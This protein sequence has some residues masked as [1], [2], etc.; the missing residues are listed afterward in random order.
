MKRN[1]FTGLLLV[2]AASGAAAQRANIGLRARAADVLNHVNAPADVE[3]CAA[4]IVELGLPI[5]PE[6]FAILVDGTATMPGGQTL[7]LDDLRLVTLYAALGGLPHTELVLYLDRVARTSESDEE[8]ERGLDLLERLGTGAE[9]RLFFALANPG[10]TEPPSLVL[11]E[12]LEQA[13]MALAQRDE[14]I[15]T[16]LARLFSRTTGPDRATI[17]TMLGSIG[18]DDA[19]ELLAGLLGTAGT[20]ADTLLLLEFLRLGADSRPVTD[21]AALE[22][23]R[24]FL[25]HPDAR[26]STIACLAVEKLRDSD[27][28]PELITLL[29]TGDPDLQARARQTLR[30]LTGIDLGPNGD[31]WMEW[32]DRSLAWWDERASACE[33]L[34]AT[35]TA[36]EAVAALE[37]VAVQRLYPER[38]APMVAIAAERSEPELRKLACRALSTLRHPSATSELVRL[39]TGPDPE[40]AAEARPF[41]RP[42]LRSSAK[43]PT[44]H[45]FR[46]P[47]PE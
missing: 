39:A 26:L 15:P 5:L 17:T 31:P 9:L 3:K 20:E 44:A 6:L 40:V 33:E 35:G 21:T 13:L 24:G 45:R 11:R 30:R 1:L 16:A 37:E 27:A 10:G 4:Q 7:Q 14:T 23:V 29:G 25:G 34:L 36:A 18:S 43:P 41:L 28:V 19:P 8:R 38:V 42:L 2:L 12:R 47:S 32:L 22:K 46:I